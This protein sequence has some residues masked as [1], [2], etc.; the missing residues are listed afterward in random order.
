MS[1]A[2]VVV[3]SVR[4]RAQ[5]SQSEPGQVR[6]V[7]P[8]S[9]QAP[10]DSYGKLPLSFEANQ[11]QADSRVKFL[12]RGS[13]YGL[14]LTAAEAIL[15]LRNPKTDTRASLDLA[16]SQSLGQDSS[17]VVFRFLRVNR[18][19]RME[20]RDQLPS[21]SNYLIGNDPSKWRTNLPTYGK[22]KYRNIYQGIDLLYYGNQRQLESD[23][24]V[25]AGAKPDAIAFA[26]EGADRL[27]IDGRGNLVIST[28]AG[29]MRLQKPVAFQEVNGMRKQVAV[30]YRLKRG[31]RVGFDLAAYDRREVLVIDPL[32]SYSS[33][34]GGSGGDHGNAIAVDSNGS[35]FVT[36]DTFSS[37]FP[38][39]AGAAQSR[40]AGGYTNVFVSKLSPD[41]SSLIYSTYL[42]G[43]GGLGGSGDS[44]V[45][46]AVD[47]AGCAYVAGTTDSADFPVTAGAFQRRYGGAQ[48]DGFVTKLSAD[49]SSLVYSTFLGGSEQETGTGIAVDS[50]GYAYVTG[51]TD[52]SDFPTTPGAFQTIPAGTTR[53]FVTKLNQDGSAL[54]YSTY[55]SG[56]M[57]VGIAIDSGGLAYVTGFAFSG[58]PTTS[59]AFQTSSASGQHA[60]VSKLNATGSSLLYSTYLGGSQNEGA[61][62]IA[63][64]SGGSALVTGY[65]YST[66]FPTTAGAL[67][68]ASGGGRDAFVTK[69]SA[70]GS[71]SEYSTYLGGSGDDA[72]Y[73][74]ALDAGG[75]AH[76]AGVTTSSDFP[77]TPG[78]F[79]TS[80]RG[81][82]DAFMTK[83]NAAGSSL[84]YSTYLG[85][86][87]GAE[88]HGIAVDS[89]GF[90]YVSGFTDSPDFPAT[91]GASQTTFGGGGSD[92]FV[93]KLAVGQPSVCSLPTLT[94]PDDFTLDANQ[95]TADVS[96]SQR[97][98]LVVHNIALGSRY[99]A[100]QISVPYFLLQTSVLPPTHAE[101]A[102]D[103]TQGPA[104]SRLVSFA[105]AQ[106]GNPAFVEAT[107]A[108]DQIPAGSSSCLVVK[109][110]Y[111][112]WQEQPEGGCE[113]TGYVNFPVKAPPLP[114]SRWKPIVEYTFTG[115]S[116]ETLQSLNIPQRL[117]LRDDNR[118]PNFA[119][120]FLD[121]DTPL[122]NLTG[123][124]GVLEIV[125]DRRE[126]TREARFRGII[127]GLP[128]YWD[129]YHQSYRKVQGPRSFPYPAPGCPECIHIHWRWGLAIPDTFPDRNHGLPLIPGGSNQDMEFAVTAWHPG[130]DHPYDFSSLLNDE[131]LGGQNLVLWHSATG[132]LPHDV[133]FAYGGFFQPSPLAMTVSAAPSPVGQAGDITYTVS[134]TNSAPITATH[135]MVDQ[136]WGGATRFQSIQSSPKCASAGL[137]EVLCDIGDVAAQSTT[138]LNIVLHVDSRYD[139]ITRSYDPLVAAFQLHGSDPTGQMA[140]TSVMTSVVP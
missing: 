118:T 102:P 75:S 54:V 17:T 56:A 133:F 26:I 125:A 135:V 14:Y 74:I 31:H 52:S 76:V 93:T 39:T 13:G 5:P 84:A 123:R 27:F 124:L 49:G 7:D 48:F 132:Y 41:G 45:G 72:G 36:G 64:N 59:G 130:E 131:P 60:F 67:Q 120:T 71:S 92:A 117:S 43:R 81:Y 91:P 23:F 6:P 40:L 12:S 47:S 79:Q 51:Y 4:H 46:I 109:Q 22:V 55:I 44:G 100:E 37:N 107:Y 28:R 95:W 15:T 78:A 98:G 25:R 101:L 85:G 77:A 136:T 116:G 80:L 32:L 83:L 1:F 30:A 129:N 96:I 70:D 88:A 42:G 33:F 24:V 62:G 128:G 20:G 139:D 57:G 97:D 38:T 87:G 29:Q 19:V 126:I 105:S 65:T 104:R 115:S 66:D 73:A 119:E 138:T 35:A 18:A 3:Q 10:L 103:G 34:L 137:N 113:P 114:C 112:F 106:Q 68:R 108:V 122:P 61:Y 9:K 63:V 94:R 90:A 99:M 21:K 140:Q 8:G 69:L 127:S 121:S 11:G 110:R 111:E 16:A 89:A 58:F 2:L 50:A 53:C 86:S 82:A 134:V